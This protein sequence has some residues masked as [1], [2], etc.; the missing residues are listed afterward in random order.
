MGIAKRQS[1]VPWSSDQCVILPMIAEGKDGIA[2]VTTDGTSLVNEPV[3]LAVSA[4]MTD[5]S[6]FQPFP[7]MARWS[8]DVFVTEKL[9][10]TNGQLCISDSGKMLVGSRN[11]WITPESDNMGFARWARQNEKALVELLGPGRHFGEWWGSGI[12]RGYGLKR[13]AFSLFNVKRWDFPWTTED[14]SLLV[15]RV[16]VLYAGPNVPGLI[17]ETM[18]YLKEVG[19]WG[20]PG[21]M[22]PE[23]IVWWHTAGGVG[24][25]KTYEN[26]EKGKGQ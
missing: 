5:L 22:D 24:F 16:P 4:D 14:D 18:K 23:G 17:E 12:Q 6:L 11:R 3:S 1:P 15:Y 20:A 21:F 10:G 13:K 7:K 9:D 19:S 25:K 2:A 8:R 26:D